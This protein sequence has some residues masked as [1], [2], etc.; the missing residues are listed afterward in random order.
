MCPRSGIRMRWLQVWEMQIKVS[1]VRVSKRVFSA[2]ITVDKWYW[3]PQFKNQRST[4]PYYKLWLVFFSFSSSFSFK[5]ENAKHFSILK[6]CMFQVLQEVW[7]DIQQWY[8]VYSICFFLRMIH[9]S[10]LK[11]ESE[12]LVIMQ[13]LTASSF[14][15]KHCNLAVH[16]TVVRYYASHFMSGNPE[17]LFIF[18]LPSCFHLN[19]RRLYQW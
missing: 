9:S 18:T 14:W 1:L 8:F 3:V 16:F 10:V 7:D 19:L 11:F 4:N 6:M 12:N 5:S 2:C 17:Y 13:A 15:P